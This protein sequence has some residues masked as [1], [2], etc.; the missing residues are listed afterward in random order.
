MPLDPS[1]AL[2]GKPVDIKPVDFNDLFKTLATIKYL[3]A[4][5]Q[6]AEQKA[7]REQQLFQET[8]AAGSY[9]STLGKGSAPTVSAPAA[10]QQPGAVTGGPPFDEATLGA[11]K[12]GESTPPPGT[13]VPGL[14]A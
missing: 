12:K 1:I 6:A 8:G 3:G 4:T 14:P 5:T 9:L 13:P 10:Q 11:L 2:Q 7:A